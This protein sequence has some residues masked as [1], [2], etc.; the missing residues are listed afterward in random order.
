MTMTKNDKTNENL[1][2]WTSDAMPWFINGT[3]DVADV[4]RFQAHLRTCE[5][6]RNQLQREKWL[7]EQIAA[8]PSTEHTPHASFYALQQRIDNAERRQQRWAWLRWRPTFLVQNRHWLTSMAIGAQATAIAV[9]AVLVFWFAQEPTPTRGYETTTRAEESPASK[10][11]VLQVVFA[12]NV[13]T[14]QITTTLDNISGRIVSGPS[15]AGLYEVELN[16]SS[17]INLSVT[18]AI[19]RLTASPTVAFVTEKTAVGPLN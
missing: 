5:Q 18:G 4:Q 1:H 2:Q 8:R 19:E 6:C 11:A 10:E 17:T 16:A 14:Q 7:F 12:K 9:L 13:T 15:K 3:L